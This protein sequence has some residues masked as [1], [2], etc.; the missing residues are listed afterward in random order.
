[1]IKEY[2]SEDVLQADCF[3]WSW[4]YRPQ[5]RRKLWHVPNGG[6]RQKVEA[7][8]FRSMGVISGVCDM[9]FIWSNQLYIIEM[10]VLDNH[11]TDNQHDF[12]IAAVGEG[13]IFYECRTLEKWQLIIDSILLKE[14]LPCEAERLVRI[15]VDKWAIAT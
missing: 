2:K 9:H 10:K 15:G 6:K 8:K 3:Q 4:K 7:V 14:A 11:I 1:M 12:I 5:T 13:A